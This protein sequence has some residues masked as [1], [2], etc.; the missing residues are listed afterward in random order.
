MLRLC[1]RYIFNAYT[2]GGGGQ[3]KPYVNH[4]YV[5]LEQPPTPDDDYTQA[6]IDGSA[7]I[8]A[9]LEGDLEWDPQVYK[10]DIEPS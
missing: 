1:I 3:K 10:P 9:G 5:I 8:L 6:V 2:R 4:A 7:P